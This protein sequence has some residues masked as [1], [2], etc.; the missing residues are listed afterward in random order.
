MTIS[1]ASV[2]FGAATSL[3]LLVEVFPSKIYDKLLLIALH[4]IWVSSSPLAPTIP[5]METSKR[6][7][8][9]SPAIAPAT[10]DKLLSRDI[11]MGISA[12]PTR[13]LNSIPNAL[14]NTTLSTIKAKS[15]FVGNIFIQESTITITVASKVPIK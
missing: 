14:D 13:M 1:V 15:A 8:I 2:I 9:A 12:P 10:P 3:C 7:F 5:P 6:S 4:I 11:V